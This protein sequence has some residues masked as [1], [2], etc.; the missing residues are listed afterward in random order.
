M[1]INVICDNFSG[2]N[3]M[4]SQDFFLYH[5]DVAEIEKR[6]VIIRLMILMVLTVI[7][8]RVCNSGSKQ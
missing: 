4:I 2:N 1:V 3:I 6:I 8:T 7:V 5:V